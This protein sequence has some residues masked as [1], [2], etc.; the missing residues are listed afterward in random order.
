MNN[1]AKDSEHL[2]RAGVE[3]M[4]IFTK[5]E[6]KFFTDKKYHTG[7][8]SPKLAGHIK[9]EFHI[10]NPPDYFEKRIIESI[11]KSNI[12][13]DEVQNRF[14]VNNAPCPIKLMSCWVNYQKKYE[15]NPIHKHDGILSFVL[16]LNIP[17]EL[18]DEEKIYKANAKNT[19]KLQFIITDIQ[20]EI[21]TVT[22]NVDKSYV[23]KLLIFNAKKYHCVY[24]FYTSNGYRITA[25]GNFGYDV[26]NFARSTKEA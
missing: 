18:E 6:L 10:G 13:L 15:F 11:P 26:E 24:P 21:R 5:E 1:L 20:G 8:Q 3:I 17:Y 22:C 14:L 19:S 25:S 16:F 12:I 9:K 7:D 23:G 2:R 4:D